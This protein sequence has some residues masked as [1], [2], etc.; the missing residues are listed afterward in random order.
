MKEI[1]L[2]S[3]NFSEETLRQMISI[4]KE[5]RF[6]P[7]DIIFTKNDL[8]NSVYIL[9][10]GEVELFIERSHSSNESTILKKMQ[11]GEIFGE[12]SF[13]TNSERTTSARSTD[14]TNVFMI[15]QEDFLMILMKNQ[16]DFQR[17]CEIKDNIKIFDNYEDLFL[18]C[19]SCRSALHQLKFCPLL[20]YIPKTDIIIQK[21]NY[22]IS[23]S[24]DD[25]IKSNKR[26]KKYNAL[27]NLEDIE[28]GAYKLQDEIFPKHETSSSSSEEKDKSEDGSESNNTIT[29]KSD[30]SSSK[31]HEETSENGDFEFEDKRRRNSYKED[32]GNYVRKIKRRLSRRKGFLLNNRS[33]SSSKK[34]INFK[35]KSSYLYDENKEDKRLR[36]N[37][38]NINDESKDKNENSNEPL[39]F[40][41]SKSGLNTN[42]TN[43]NN[44]NGNN[45][46]NID[47]AQNKDDINHDID[48]VK[49]FDDY[50]SHNN[51]ETILHGLEMKKFK[52][53]SKKIKKG[54]Y[55]KTKYQSFFQ[56]TI[57]INH[58]I[59]T[60]LR[61]SNLYGR[62]KTVIFKENLK[63]KQ[64]FL[65]KKN[66]KSSLAI[67]KYYFKNSLNLQKLIE[68]E[69][70]NPDKIKDYYK[71]KYMKNKN[72]WIVYLVWKYCRSKALILIRRLLKCV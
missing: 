55:L 57:D 8:S 18:R 46:K 11:P 44:K 9:R 7:G 6:T 64:K 56:N 24:R 13:F 70:F 26:L 23:Q 71:Q 49:S 19:F 5:V 30:Y 20:H 61:G 41:R 53:L 34:E 60:F 50:Y 14:F 39:L 38:S 72:K 10:R 47:V 31:S 67:K 22:S 21:S 40:L 62:K 69:S 65:E 59:P 2:F 36:R 12:L 42:T 63:K 1:K 51:I 68:Q 35:K 48:K 25:S 52:K 33:L 28:K 3:L 29:E 17:F 43:D 27:Q 32:E 15:K 58:T 66:R 37:P 54:N 45:Q 16:Q 4:M